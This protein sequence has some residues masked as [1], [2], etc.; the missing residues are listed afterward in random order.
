VAK[1][2]PF[3][4]GNTRFSLLLPVFF[5][6]RPSLQAASLRET[7]HMQAGQCGNQIGTNFWEV[8]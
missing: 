4:F 7:A 5:L 2:L 6:P 8:V 3:P 1:P